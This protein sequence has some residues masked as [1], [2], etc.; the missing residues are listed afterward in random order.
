MRRT[1]WTSCQSSLARVRAG[2]ERVPLRCGVVVRGAGARGVADVH[3]LAARGPVTEQFLAF[4]SEK[5]AG[6]GDDVIALLKDELAGDET[7]SP[8]EVVGT[9]LAPVSGNVFLGN[10]VND[11]ANPGPHAG[12]GAHGTRLV[13]GVENEVGQIPAIT[14]RYVFERFQLH[15]LDA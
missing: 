4:L 7:R 12:A 8:L 13:R 10:A 3:Q 14:A 9:L 5:T 1:S 15:V 6:D 2:W 11:R